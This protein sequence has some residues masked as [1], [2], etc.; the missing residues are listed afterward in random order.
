[1]TFT[2]KRKWLTYYEIYIKEDCPYKEALFD[3][4]TVPTGL[5]L[6]FTD[7]CTQRPKRWGLNVFIWERA[8]IFNA[9]IYMVC[10]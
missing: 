7:G 10:Y 8:C 3:G 2:D 4:G 1:M 6:T 9:Y 5:K